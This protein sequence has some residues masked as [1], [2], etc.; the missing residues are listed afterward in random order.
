MAYGTAACLGITVAVAL[1]ATLPLWQRVAAADLAGTLAIF[2]FSVALNN[3]SVYDAYWSVA[4]AVIA[5]MALVTSTGT[6]GAGSAAALVVVWLWAARLTWNWARGW[7]GMGHEDWRY[8]DLRRSTGR[9]YWLVS[10]VGLHVFPTILVFLG[11]VPLLAVFT[12]D[13]LGWSAT[14]AAGLSLSL[15]G[16]AVEAVADEQLRAFRHRARPGEVL[17]EGLWAHSRHPNYLGEMLFWWGA[18]VAGYAAGA[19]GWA[20]FG[21]AVAV[22]LLFVFVSVPLLDRRSLARRPAYAA[23]MAQVPG[24]FPRPWRRALA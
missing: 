22:H 15:V 10:L 7:A 4:P 9:A 8:V 1:P 24:I 13:D 20:C 19:R 3:S 17:A 6:L 21:G 5:L 12:A 18:A 14:L 23:H 11:C 2:G 16:T